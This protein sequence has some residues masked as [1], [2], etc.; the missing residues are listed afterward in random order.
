MADNKFSAAD[1]V[2]VEAYERNGK[3]V[4]GYVRR[5]GGG[6]ATPEETEQFY[7]EKYGE[8]QS[9]SKKDL[10][11]SEFKEFSQNLA[12]E[13]EADYLPEIENPQTGELVESLYEF[14]DP[15]LAAGNCYDVASSIEE[16]MSEDET[17]TVETTIENV[18]KPYLINHSANIFTNSQGE[19]FVVDFTYS[20]INPDAD[21]PYVSTL[22]EWKKNVQNAGDNP[23]PR[24]KALLYP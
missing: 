8:T 9:I 3:T 13:I 5:I 18:N 7:A 23:D 16:Y 21:F 4:Q 17:Y 22:E 24:V 6:R 1:F 12:D 20:Q 19:S 10:K 14:R 2:E 11:I 15:G